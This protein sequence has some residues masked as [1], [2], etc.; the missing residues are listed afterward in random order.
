MRT[1]FLILTVTFAVLMFTVI[2]LPL[3]GIRGWGQALICV[4]LIG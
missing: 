3:P 2:Q 1:L 4:Y